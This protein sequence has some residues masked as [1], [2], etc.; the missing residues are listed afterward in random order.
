MLLDNI[1]NNQ[2]SDFP[3]FSVMQA[4]NFVPKL[5]KLRKETLLLVLK[6]Q[7]YISKNHILLGLSCKPIKCMT[8]KQQNARGSI[9]IGTNFMN[10]QVF[11]PQKWQLSNKHSYQSTYTLTLLALIISPTPAASNSNTVYEVEQLQTGGFELY[12]SY[13]SLNDKAAAK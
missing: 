3:I 13:S 4:V 2:F 1:T 10:L 6:V 9:G 11:L 8:N 7:N 5:H 12:C